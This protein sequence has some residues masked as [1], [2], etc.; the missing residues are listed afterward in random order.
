MGQPVDQLLSG[1]ILQLPEGIPYDS[2]YFIIFHYIS[3]YCIVF[4]Y[5][6]LY[7]IIFH[8][9]SLYF[10]IFHYIQLYFHVFPYIYIYMFSHVP[11]YFHMLSPPWLYDFASG[12]MAPVLPCCPCPSP[13]SC[14]WR[15]SRRQSSRLRWRRWTVDGQTKMF[16]E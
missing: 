11:A 3:L 9:I 4:H 1:V 10:I 12:R 14:C 6:S 7:F 13:G 8:E 15:I 2:L 5:I 16:D